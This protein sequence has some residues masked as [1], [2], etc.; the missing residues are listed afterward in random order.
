MSKFSIRSTD[1]QALGPLEDLMR[2][3]QPDIDWVDQ[4]IEY[5]L[6]LMG[7]PTK[8]PS[9]KAQPLSEWF[10]GGCAPCGFVA[11][12]PPA[13]TPDEVLVARVNKADF[14]TESPFGSKKNPQLHMQKVHRLQTMMTRNRRVLNMHSEEKSCSPKKSRLQKALGRQP[15]QSQMEAKA[16][17]RPT[18]I[19]VRNKEPWYKQIKLKLVRAMERLRGKKQPSA[20]DA[21]IQ[22]IKQ[23]SRADGTKRAEQLIARA[24]F[25]ATKAKRP[26]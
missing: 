6:Q 23:T 18:S 26:R 24:R 13:A 1:M 17:G 16:P 12:T 21:A 7:M 25:H 10:G 8:A 14:S 20:R 5:G 3:L 11:V 4:E 15:P 19:R 22:R 9:I 2:D